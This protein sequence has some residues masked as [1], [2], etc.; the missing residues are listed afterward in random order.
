MHTSGWSG[1]DDFLISALLQ[2]LVCIAPNVLR[3]KICRRLHNKN[4]FD[5]PD[6]VVDKKDSDNGKNEVINPII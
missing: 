6:E 4:E 2:A 5:I 1:L 3:E